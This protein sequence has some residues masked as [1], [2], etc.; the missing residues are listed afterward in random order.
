MKEDFF[1]LCDRL[2]IM[3]W[4]EFPLA[5]NDYPDDLDYL[6][7]L[8]QESRSIIFRLKPHPSV[9]LWCGGNELFNVWSGMDDQS[10]PLRLLNSNCYQLDPERPFIYTSPLD[11]AA[12]GPYS[13]IDFSTNMETWALFQQSAFTAYCEFGA[14]SAMP[15]VDS[16]RTFIPQEALFPVSNHPAWLAHHAITAQMKPYHLH[17]EAIEEYFGPS[18]SLEELVERS[19]FLQA[20]G[21]H[22]DF[23]EVR[24]QKMEA[25]MAIN[26]CFNEPWPNAANLSII[27]WPDMPKPG[28]Y[29]VGEALRPVLASARIRK[30][31]WKAGELFDPELWVLSDSPHSTPAGRVEAWLKIGEEELFLLEWKYPAIEPA[32]NLKGPK[33]QFVLPVATVKRFQLI[34]KLPEHAEMNSVY[35]LL[36]S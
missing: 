18:V 19:Q 22:G 28:L 6:K 30:M 33:I 35:T 2:G 24:R 7:V 27:A 17:L 20:E 16:L 29:R 23:E 11:G 14:G 13:T 32:V 12:H 15:S 26:W 10:L 4:Q 31:K 5:C 3:V 8:D 34:L 9:V 25:S 1:D 36:I 21:L